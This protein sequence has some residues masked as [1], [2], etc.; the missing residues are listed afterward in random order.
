MKII[1]TPKELEKDGKLLDELLNIIIADENIIKKIKE[2][3][4]NNKTLQSYVFTNDNFVKMYLLIMRT[5]ANIPTI[6]M[7]E[8]GCGKTKLLQMFSF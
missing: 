8:T 4:N 1:K 7:G 3:I 5:R 2:I 6:I